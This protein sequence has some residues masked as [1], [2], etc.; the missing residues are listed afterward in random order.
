MADGQLSL[1]GLACG[2]IVACVPTRLSALLNS[3]FY[4]AW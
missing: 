1:G 2:K 4:N 3:F